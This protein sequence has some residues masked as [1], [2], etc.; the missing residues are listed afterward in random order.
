MLNWL[1]Q[2]RPV[3]FLRCHLR[4]TTKKNKKNKLAT[5]TLGQAMLVVSD[6]GQHNKFT[7]FNMREITQAQRR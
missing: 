7:H 3:V 5:R 1:I 6:G 4:A 2:D